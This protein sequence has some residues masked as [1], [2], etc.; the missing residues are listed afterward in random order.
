MLFQYPFKPPNPI[1]A[2]TGRY[3]PLKQILASIT[4]RK[5]VDMYAYYSVKLTSF[6]LIK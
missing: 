2:N 4:I 5:P 3:L 6:I 1:R